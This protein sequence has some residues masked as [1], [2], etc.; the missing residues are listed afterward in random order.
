MWCCFLTVAF[1]S[2][3]VLL[4]WCV[5]VATSRVRENLYWISLLLLLLTSGTTVRGV[6]VGLTAVL[7][8]GLPE[9]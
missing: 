8:L 4:F 3:L 2:V 1:G 9:W 5:A 6:G 7:L